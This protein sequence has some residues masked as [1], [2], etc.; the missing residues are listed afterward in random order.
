MEVKKGGEPLER[1]YRQA[2]EYLQR[3]VP[4]RPRN[5]VLCNF[6]AFWV[7]WGNDSDLQVG[8]LRTTGILLD[9][10]LQDGSS[11]LVARVSEPLKQT[12]AEDLRPALLVAPA[13]AGVCHERLQSF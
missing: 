5:A 2:F 10:V 12:I 3:L 8:E 4:H 13:R 1:H 9:V 7:Y 11:F 6:R